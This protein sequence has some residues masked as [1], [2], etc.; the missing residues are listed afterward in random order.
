MKKIDSGALFDLARA[1]GFDD[2]RIVQCTDY[3]CKSK[4]NAPFETKSILVLF[5]HYRPGGGRTDGR[6]GIS[7]YYAVSNKA[8]ANAGMLAE[9]LAVNGIPALR[10]SGLPARRIALLSG[11]H[12]GKNGFYYHPDFGSLVHIQTIRLGAE[13]RANDSRTRA[14]CLHCGACIN[15]CPAGA[16]TDAGV[17][18]SKCLRS[19][20]DGAVPDGMKPFIYQ[21]LG[22]EIC[23]TAC[24]MNNAGDSDTP[25]FDLAA[26]LRGETMGELKELAG[27]NMAR[28]MRITNQ[29]VIV[30]ANRRELSVL[31]EISAL[32]ADERFA[33]ACRYYLEMTG[34]IPPKKD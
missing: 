23:Q 19:H 29:A 24:P 18:A 32:A 27:K 12:L 15:A 22:C 1:A 10:D 16:V 25:D 34:Q 5:S 17:D 30:A 33:D 26:T 3:D 2:A 8:Y 11:G 28:L 9:R 31:P 13:V 6:I 14:E 21:L 7:A 20:M 4:E